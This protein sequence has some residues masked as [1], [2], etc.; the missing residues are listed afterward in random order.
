MMDHLLVV[1]IYE[2][3]PPLTIQSLPPADSVDSV[4]SPSIRAC[5]APP[6]LLQPLYISVPAQVTVTRKYQIC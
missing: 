5:C 4:D 2:A 1:P 6:T 3:H